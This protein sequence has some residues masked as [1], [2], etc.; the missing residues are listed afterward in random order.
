MLSR[1]FHHYFIF[2]L[3]LCIVGVNFFSWGILNLLDY[4]FVPYQPLDLSL[5]FMQNAI[6]LVNNIVW[7]SLASRWI[8]FSILILAGYCGYRIAC[9]LV[10]YAFHTRSSIT[11]SLAI[12][13]FMMNPFLYERMMTQPTIALGIILLAW[14][15]YFLLR[16]LM[17]EKS[18]DVRGKAYFLNFVWVGVTM[19]LSW[20]IFYHA[21]YMIGVIFLL[22]VLFFVRSKKMMLGMILAISIILLLNMNWIVAQFFLPDTWPLDTIQAF[23]RENFVAFMTRSLAP[24]SVT[25]TN[26][27]LYGFWGEIRHFALPSSLSP[28][29]YVWGSM[30]LLIPCISWAWHV[31]SKRATATKEVNTSRLVLFF[32]SLGLIALIFWLG[33]ATPW[34]QGINE[35]A[36]VNLPFFSGYREPQKWIGLLMIAEWYIFILSVATLVQRIRDRF[37]Q[38]LFFWFTLFCLFLWSPGMLFSFRWQLTT[39]EY[40]KSFSLLRASLWDDRGLK[41]MLLLPWHSYMGCDWTAGRVI[42][43]P[44]PYFFRPIE[45]VSADN[46]EMWNLYSN[47]SHPESKTIEAFLGDKGKSREKFFQIGFTHILVARNCATKDE[48]LWIGSLCRKTR[49][50]REYMLYVCRS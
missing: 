32:L 50:E 43:N 37:F 41:K 19:G 31:F 40:P 6:L 8:F 16:P 28:Y 39:M 22:S 1:V 26:I 47:S 35:W 23:S 18:H 38:Y 20:S 42:S 12:V 9:D 21:S 10:S 25:F 33:I 15:V 27:L 46:I 48:F 14:G 4:I 49:E 34:T 44:L 45:T 7:S 36:Y 30:I 3:A 24:L 11:E 17:L 13:F 29:W 5:P 2:W